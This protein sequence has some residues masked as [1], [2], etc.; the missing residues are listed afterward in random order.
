ADLEDYRDKAQEAILKLGNLP[1]AMKAFKAMP[2][3]PTAECCRLA[4]DADALVVLVAYRYGFVPSTELGG[5]GQRSITWLEVESARAAGRRVYAFLIDPNYPWSRDREETRLAKQP[6][7]AAEITAA[8]RQLGAFRAYL[9]ARFTPA[10]FTTPDNLA[11]QVAT[12]LT[13]LA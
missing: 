1:V 2:G 6:E 4:A 7:Q 8:V 13:G 10:Y 5:D 11:Y 9:Q 3:T 12:A